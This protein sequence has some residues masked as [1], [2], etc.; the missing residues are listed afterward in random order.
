MDPHP[1]QPATGRFPRHARGGWIDP[2]TVHLRWV[3]TIVP[4]LTGIS[5]LVL[6]LVRPIDGL[7]AAALIVLVSGTL[8][9]PLLWA[10]TK[11]Y[12]EYAVLRA[13]FWI[14][15]VVVTVAVA[16]VDHIAPFTIA[17][18]WPVALAGMLA[19]PRETAVVAVTT[20]A[21]A[22]ASPLLRDVQPPAVVAVNAIALLAI[23][24]M[25]AALRTNEHR[26]MVDRRN[27]GRQLEDAQ[28][29]ARIG[30]YEYDPASECAR[31]SD[32]LYRIFGLPKG[33]AVDRGSFLSMVLEDDRERVT[34]VTAAAT[35]LD[36][37]CR[38]RRP[39]GR[40]VHVHVLGEQVED[41]RGPL[42]IG[43]VQDITELRR[44]DAMR[45]EFVAAASHELRTPTSVVLGFATT[46][47]RRWEELSEADR[48]RFV[49]QIDGSA[50][51]LALLIEDVLQVTQVESGQ[52]RCQR[53]PFDL[54]A[55][56]VDLVVTWPGEA[57]IALEVDPAAGRA[58]G[59]AVRTRQV[60]GNLLAN[61][62][63]YSPAGAGVR[64][65]VSAG[66]GELRVDVTDHGPGI[67]EEAQGRIFERFVRLSSDAH[68]TGLG[69]YISRQLAEAQ[70]GTLDVAS[71]P[72]RGSTFTYRLPA[73]PGRVET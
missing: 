9:G 62:E 4:T 33:S 43:T 1:L 17:Y 65:R 55:E 64:V 20:A 58:I 54:A 36:Y 61:A 40:V 71:E 46:L 42:L 7:L 31:W 57:P 66:E 16:Q 37:A 47:T 28:R 68:G 49:E 60:V 39:D 24:A 70:G 8:V 19:S 13:S 32:E 26:A 10:A 11:R 18:M 59:D 51:R 5:L 72:G 48:R 41:E 6:W 52:V 38:I 44:L 14:D 34:A 2:V 35:T 23:G 63:R 67:P 27:L 45:D 69:L 73:D 25:I 3:R 12:G 15:L 53:Q 21:I 22:I 29:L 50:R 30:S 56:V